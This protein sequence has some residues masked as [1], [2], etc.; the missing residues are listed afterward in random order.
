MKSYECKWGI[1]QQSRIADWSGEQDKAISMII[2][3]AKDL[4]SL[5]ARENIRK[6]KGRRKMEQV[7]KLNFLF[8]V[9]MKF[10][11]CT[12]MSWYTIARNIFCGIFNFVQPLIAEYEIFFDHSNIFR[13]PSHMTDHANAK[14]FKLIFLLQNILC[15]LH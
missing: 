13:I 14:T 3:E 7:F 8:L 10:S 4:I 11:C 12:Y 6:M 15:L 1:H 5:W 2:N 9:M